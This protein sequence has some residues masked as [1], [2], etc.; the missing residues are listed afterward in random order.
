MTPTDIYIDKNGH[1]LLIIY[2]LQGHE[3]RNTGRLPGFFPVIRGS[4]SR[5]GL[6]GVIKTGHFAVAQLRS[7]FFHGT[8]PQRNQFQCFLLADIG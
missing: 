4:G 8:I 2:I 1:V 7:Y 3:M 6:K 5:P